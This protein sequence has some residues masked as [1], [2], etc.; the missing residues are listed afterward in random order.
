M[1]SRY[2]TT[3]NNHKKVKIL[4]A[5]NSVDS[6]VYQVSLTMKSSVEISITVL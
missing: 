6:E 4:Y 2:L 5:K 1:I 3:F